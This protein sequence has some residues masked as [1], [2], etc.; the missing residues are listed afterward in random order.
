MVYI[1]GGRFYPQETKTFDDFIC[2]SGDGPDI[3]LMS[4]EDY[5]ADPVLLGKGDDGWHTAVVK[6]LT[7]SQ[8]KKMLGRINGCTPSHINIIELGRRG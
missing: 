3:T 8:A 6:E 4:E 7:R 2:V 1:I 5:T